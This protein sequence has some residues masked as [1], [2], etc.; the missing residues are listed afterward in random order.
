MI[1][2][3]IKIAILVLIGKWLFGGSDGDC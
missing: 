1:I 3:L 2:F